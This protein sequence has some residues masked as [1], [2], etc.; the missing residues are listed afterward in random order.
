MVEGG[1]GPPALFVTGWT[2]T[3]D[4]FEPLAQQYEPHLR[5][6]RYDHR[7]TGRS[8]RWDRP[9]SMRRLADDAAR[10]LDAA[11]LDS[12]H[13]VGLSMGGFVAL[14]LALRH[15]ERVRSLILVGTAGSGVPVPSPHWLRGGAALARVAGASLRSRR[16][17]P[18]AA[19]F[20]RTFVRSD[21]RRARTLARPFTERPMRPATIAAQT[22]AV[23]GFDRTRALR[24]I[25]A[26]TLVAHGTE[27]AMVSPHAARSL[28]QRLPEAELRLFPGAGHAV[29]MEQPEAFGAVALAFVARVERRATPG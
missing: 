2:V 9:V 13:V 15:P 7:G 29:P 16:L 11:G 5:C 1:T 21:P 25:R 19:I 17:A 4:I 24:E 3:H 12:A 10:V 20:S 26:P 6:V 23:A 14:E 28:A 18:E 27:D 22:L 8:A